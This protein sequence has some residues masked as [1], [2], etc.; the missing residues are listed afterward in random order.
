MSS[1]YGNI[2][3]REI[4]KPRASKGLIMINLEERGRQV[5]IIISKMKRNYRKDSNKPPGRL[6]IF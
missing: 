2:N 5:I 4:K 6:S 1:N 3:A